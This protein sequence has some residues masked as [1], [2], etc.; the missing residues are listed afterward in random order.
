MTVGSRHYPSLARAPAQC[1]CPTGR[2]DQSVVQL[3][4]FKAG[5][6]GGLNG[7]VMSSVARLLTEE[8]IQAVALYYSTLRPEVIPPAP[9]GGARLPLEER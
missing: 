1:S 7:V 9:Q 4:L 8:Q 5:V 6:R 2:R 3:Q